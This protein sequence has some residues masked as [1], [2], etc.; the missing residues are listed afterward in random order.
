MKQFLCCDYQRYVNFT[1]PIYLWPLVVIFCSRWDFF[2]SNVLRSSRSTFSF[3]R[4]FLLPLVSFSSLSYLLTVTHRK[5]VSLRGEKYDWEEQST[6]ERRKVRLTGEKND[7]EEKQQYNTDLVSP[8][9]AYFRVYLDVRTWKIFYV[10]E[11]V[12]LLY[13]FV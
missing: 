5:K 13:A 6:T 2:H 9:T 4:R 1:F 12:V 10:L 8:A 3:L 11:G 7:W